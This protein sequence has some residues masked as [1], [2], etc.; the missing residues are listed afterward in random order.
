M[1]TIRLATLDD[2]RAL[3]GIERSAGMA[4]RETEHAWVADEPDT[5]AEA[6][7]PLVEAGGVWVAEDDGALAGFASTEM[8][9]GDLHIL[10]LAV[11]RDHQRRG[12]GRALMAA[13]RDEALA[14]QCPAMT[15]T[16]FRNV[17]FNAPFYEGLGFEILADPSP[18]LREILEQEAEHGLTE[19][20]A[21]RA[22]L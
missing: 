12:I 22:A 9:D 15:L 3:P 13:V 2:I 11:L 17:A 1:I 7:P 18:S 16:T 20:C 5:E 8:L 21:M 4:F 6:Y 14:R 10:E 19:R